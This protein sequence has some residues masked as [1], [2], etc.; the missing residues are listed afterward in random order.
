MGTEKCA[1]VFLENM[2]TQTMRFQFPETMPPP[3]VGLH[4]SPSVGHILPKGRKAITFTFKPLQRLDDTVTLP[5]TIASI[6][7]L[8]DEEDW[9]DSMRSVTFEDGASTSAEGSR[10][11]AQNCGGRWARVASEGHV[12]E[13]EQF[14][15]VQAGT[16]TSFMSFG[17]DEGTFVYYFRCLLLL[18]SVLDSA[19]F[20]FTRAWTC[21]HSISFALMPIGH[22]HRALSHTLKKGFGLIY[23]RCRRW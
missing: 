12:G 22:V 11:C 9:D 2:S 14:S 6:S 13:E 3:F 5:I 8:G 4:V 21:K 1:T 20:A 10:A 17:L 15:D 19:W 7:Y 16:L 18:Y 23:P